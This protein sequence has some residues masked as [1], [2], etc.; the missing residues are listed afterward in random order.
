MN[1]S[2]YASRYLHPY[3][4]LNTC[5]DFLPFSK[6]AQKNKT[7]LLISCFDSGEDLHLKWEFSYVPGNLGI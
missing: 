5:F 7:S 3:G 2:M 1:A 6:G 4:C